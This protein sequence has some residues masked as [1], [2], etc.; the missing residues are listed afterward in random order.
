[1]TDLSKVGLKLPTYTFDVERVK[2]KEFVQAI[3]DDNPIYQDKEIAL[4]EGYRDTPCPPTFITLAFQEFTGAYFRV[5]EE[6]GISLST[7]LHGEEEYHYLGEIYPGD[8]LVCEM[9]V[10]SISQKQTKSGR[11]DLITL[12]TLFTNQRGE[13]VL[14]ARSLIIERKD[15]PPE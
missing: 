10:E 5:F 9:R 13:D 2:I 8:R 7:V 14:E 3:G 12:K 1:M 6:L 4:A 15:K 11:M